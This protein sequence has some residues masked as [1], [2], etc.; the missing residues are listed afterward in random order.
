M[1]KAVIINTHQFIGKLAILQP[2]DIVQK[3]VGICHSILRRKLNNMESIKMDSVNQSTWTSTWEKSRNVDITVA[4]YSQNN[5]WHKP[6]ASREMF[7][8]FQQILTFLLF[9]LWHGVVVYVFF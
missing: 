4:I 9:Y 5:L 2:S 6:T 3:V 7:Y 1:I 8:S